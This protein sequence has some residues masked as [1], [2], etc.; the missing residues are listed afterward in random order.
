M[1]IASS[2]VAKK[3]RPHLDLR[4]NSVRKSHKPATM[5]SDRLRL[6]RKQQ[7]EEHHCASGSTLSICSTLSNIHTPTHNLGT[8]VCTTRQHVS[9][10]TAE[11]HQLKKAQTVLAWAT[12]VPHSWREKAA[13]AKTMGVGNRFR[14]SE[15]IIYIYIIYIYV[16]TYFFF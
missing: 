8:W 12:Q 4:Q 13:F 2:Q 16:Q 10:N 7:Q 6:F 14:L 1:S 5:K 9:S 11:K 3:A 15:Y